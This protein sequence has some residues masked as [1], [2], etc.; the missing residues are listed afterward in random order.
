MNIIS[1]LRAPQVIDDGYNREKPHQSLGNPTPF[2]LTA[3]F[4][5]SSLALLHMGLAGHKVK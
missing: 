3:T 2:P 1:W 4:I 5:S